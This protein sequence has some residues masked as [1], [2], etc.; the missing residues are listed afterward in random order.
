M[1]VMYRSGQSI[2]LDRLELTMKSR[3]MFCT[4][5]GMITVYMYVSYSR[6]KS[7]IHNVFGQSFGH[8]SL[9]NLS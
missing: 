8:C 3:K 1:S 5:V 7:Y 9:R 2:Q 6:C 4:L